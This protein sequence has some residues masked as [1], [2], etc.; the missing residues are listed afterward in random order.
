VKAEKR[1]GSKQKHAKRKQSAGG[2][3]N[4]GG[5]QTKHTMR[6]EE[7]PSHQILQPGLVPP[8][9]GSKDASQSEDEHPGGGPC[10]DAE[11]AAQNLGDGTT[12]VM[13]RN[14]PNRYVCEELLSELIAATFEDFDFFYLPIDFNTKR[15]RGYAFVNFKSAQSAKLFTLAFHGQQLTRY[16]SREVLEIAPAV[17]QGFEAN[18]KIYMKKDGKRVNNQ[19]F[20]PLI[21]TSDDFLC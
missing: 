3:Q 2:K 6:Q 1:K 8:V 19:W 17:T 18:M 15:N 5:C 7:T 9:S 4:A 10:T 14:V 16:A 20:R 21:F 11:T 13:V 12:T